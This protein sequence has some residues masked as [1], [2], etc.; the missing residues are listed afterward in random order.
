MADANAIHRYGWLLDLFVVL[1]V[2]NEPDFICLAV[3][4]LGM[5]E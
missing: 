5:M 2:G 3:A 4:V 1:S